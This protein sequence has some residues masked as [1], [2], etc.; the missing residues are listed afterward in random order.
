AESGEPCLIDDLTQ[1]NWRHVTDDAWA[2]CYLGAPIRVEGKTVGFLSL[3]AARPGF[4]TAEQAERLM[5]FANQTA[6]ALQKVRLIESLHRLATTDALTGLANRRHLLERA[7]R[8][9]EHAR[10]YFE[11]IS[12]LMLDIDHFKQVNDTYGHAAGDE[13]LRTVAEVCAAALRKVD[14]IGRY[15]GEEFAALLPETR[16]HDAAT[17]AERLA[18]AVSDLPFDIQGRLLHVTVSV[19][20]AEA[21]GPGDTLARL[22]DR[23]DQAMYRAKQAGR[24]RVVVFD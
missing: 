13:V 11:P 6:V 5:A 23:A 16:L 20:V 4:F 8:E 24:N 10:R 15:G 9:F 12:A 18:L 14:V 21:Q 22:I 7:E 19:G 1:Y 17:V 3:M 2:R